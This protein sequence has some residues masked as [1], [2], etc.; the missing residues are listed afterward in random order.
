MSE[1]VLVRHG[2]AS[3]GEES[4]DKLSE[5]GLRQMQVLAQYW[6]QTGE[7]FD[8]VF[9]GELRR[10]IETASILLPM[11]SGSPDRPT[12]L[13]ALNEYSGSPLIDIYLRDHAAEDGFA[14][15]VRSRLHERKV[16]QQV[17]EAATA[18]WINHQ[19][20]PGQEDIE[21]ET[22]P[23]FQHRVHDTIA[24]LIRECGSGQQLLLSTSGG[25]IA[26]AV[27]YVLGLSD[28]QAMAMNWTINN[29]SITR[30]RFGGGRI[31]LA[32]FNGLAHLERPEFKE[33]ITF[34]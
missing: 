26:L 25:V 19:L 13:S 12:V 14:P 5:T 6:Q 33:L 22:W 23:D 1:L 30:I 32:L 2:Q 10:Q 21:F 27:Q 3:F 28:A 17:F 18:R 15:E 8:A 31:S 7:R 24:G 20:Q 34:R 16:F 4:Y 29:S 11:V 9:S